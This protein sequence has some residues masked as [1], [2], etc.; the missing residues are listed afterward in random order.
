MDDDLQGFARELTEL[1]LTAGAPSYRAMA[2]KT[3]YS[4]TTLAQ[5][6][7]GR[8]L[9]SLPVTMAFVRACNG[10]VARWERRWCLL[11]ASTTPAVVAGT[12]R[13][14]SAWPEQLVADGAE[15]EAAGCGHD[16][17][18]ACAR[19]VAL[20]ERR[21]IIGQVELRYC[22]RAHATWGRFEG[23]SGLDHLATH[24]HE[25]DIDIEVFREDDGAQMSFRDR[26]MFDYHWSDL[27][28]TGG[29]RFRACATVYFDGVNVAS[30][31]TDTV[32]LA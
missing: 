31:K 19:K 4:R 11:H 28:K 12:P 3:H 10:D 14:S 8:S 30:A 18:T 22:P 9:P 6:A 20:H 23:F 21:H 5:A 26:Y 25:T 2:L 13:I 17:V 1:R 32:V 24:R 15:P 16:A 7:G 27:L 29:E